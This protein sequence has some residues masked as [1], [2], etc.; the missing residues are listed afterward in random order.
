MSYKVIFR[1]EVLNNDI[2]TGMSW[3]DQLK[4]DFTKFNTTIHTSSP[5]V[6]QQ[7]EM[8][9][10]GISVDGTIYPV[11]FQT[12]GADLGILFKKLYKVKTLISDITSNE[13][14]LHIKNNNVAEVENFGDSMEKVYIL[15]KMREN[16]P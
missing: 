1:S 8:S 11:D 12:K 7:F 2:E 14:R 16:K 10:V 9:D 6:V 13:L 3:L 5:I 15:R 4:F